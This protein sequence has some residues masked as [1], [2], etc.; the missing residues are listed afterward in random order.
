MSGSNR[1]LP[2]LRAGRQALRANPG[3]AK[4][5]RLAS[6]VLL[7]PAHRRPPRSA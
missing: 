2:R 4:V 5:V 7:L 1:Y 6:Y 3:A